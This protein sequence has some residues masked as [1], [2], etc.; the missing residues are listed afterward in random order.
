MRSGAAK[1]CP[2]C[3]EIKPI[4]DFKDR[5]L[6]TGLG[7]FCLACK[8]QP[9]SWKYVPVDGDRRVKSENEPSKSDVNKLLSFSENPEKY[10]TVTSRAKER[11]EYLES[12]KQKFSEGQLTKYTMARKKYDAAVATKKEPGIQKED[13]S[14]ILAEAFMNHKS[15]KIRYKG[16][17]RTID[18]YALNKTYVVAYCHIARDIRTFRVDRI[19]GAELSSGFSFDRSLQATAQFRLVE[20]PS[21]KGGGHRRRY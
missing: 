16:S 2:Q 3:G 6:V 20:A 15:V 10:A 5:S 11:V 13:F 4:S 7:R 9:S 21:Y 8:A 12:I 17:W 1:V 14:T 18:P 19:Q